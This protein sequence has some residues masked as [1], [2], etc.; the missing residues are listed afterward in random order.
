MPDK[1]KLHR[2]K[3]VRILSDKNLHRLAMNIVNQLFDLAGTPTLKRQEINDQC[4]QFVYKIIQEYHEAEKARK[5]AKVNQEAQQLSS[6]GN[7]GEP[8]GI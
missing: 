2:A 8:R 4:D 6:E 3:F 1:T 5:I 7:E